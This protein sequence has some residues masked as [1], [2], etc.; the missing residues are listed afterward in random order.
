LSFA[1]KDKG[2]SERVTQRAEHIRSYRAN[3]TSQAELLLKSS[4]KK[5]P[6]LLAALS[7]QCITAFG[8]LGFTVN[9]DRGEKES[10]PRCLEQYGDDLF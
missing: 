3:V 10:G 8:G 5:L 1:G 2:P 6:G 4:L 9:T 7:P